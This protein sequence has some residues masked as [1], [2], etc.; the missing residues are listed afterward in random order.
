MPD[1]TVVTV[2]GGH[3]VTW[4][5]FD[6]TAS[7]IIEFLENPRAERARDSRP[8]ARRYRW[9]VEDGIHLDDV[10]RGEEVRLG[11]E[12]ECRCASR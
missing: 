12:L 10:E 8:R 3:I 4:D 6:E 1:C 5:A 9:D 2:P 11:D 7:A